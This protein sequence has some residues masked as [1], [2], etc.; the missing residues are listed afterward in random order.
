MKILQDPY[1]LPFLLESSAGFPADIVAE[2]Y[3]K[4]APQI[5]RHW[6]RR[7]SPLTNRTGSYEIILSN[8]EPWTENILLDVPEVTISPVRST[9][10]PL[11]K[12]W[13][14]IASRYITLCL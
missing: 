13:E 14:W 1:L 9:V 12:K 4:Q 7:E 5:H 8:L 10:K 6:A 11:T 3:S 2:E